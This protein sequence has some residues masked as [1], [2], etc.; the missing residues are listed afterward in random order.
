[1][2]VLMRHLPRNPWKYLVDAVLEREIAFASAP[3]E[4]RAVI[5]VH[6]TATITDDSSS[7]QLSFD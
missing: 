3:L 6:L 2:T 1:M 7:L 4:R 5:D